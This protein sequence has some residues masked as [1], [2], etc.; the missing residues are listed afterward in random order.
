MDARQR[1]NT[2]PDNAKYLNYLDPVIT[3]DKVDLACAN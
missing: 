2:N 1:L 3:G